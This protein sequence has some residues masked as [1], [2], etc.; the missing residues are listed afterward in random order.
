MKEEKLVAMFLEVRTVV[1]KVLCPDSS[2]LLDTF[3]PAYAASLIRTLT[4]RKKSPII[5]I[6][7]YH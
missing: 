1:K 5:C 6:F 7:G 2:M 4:Y 3:I